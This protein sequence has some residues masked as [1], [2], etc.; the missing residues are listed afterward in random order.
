MTRNHR[1]EALCRAYVQAVA[2]LAGLATSKPEPDY[3]IDLSLRHI[4]EQGQQFLDAGILL[5]LQLRST[6]RAALSADEVRYDLDVRTYDLLRYTE[7]LPRILVVLV[8]PDDEGRWLRLSQEELVVRHA[9]YWCS[10]RG[11]PATTA[12]SSVRI[13][14]PRA[15]LFS[16]EGVRAVMNRPLRG[17]LP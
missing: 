12:M 9:A 10:L 6:T 14:I 7:G 5:D 3:G 16:V 8:L 4:G 1:Q 13:T 2:A 15:Q 11:G 17:Q